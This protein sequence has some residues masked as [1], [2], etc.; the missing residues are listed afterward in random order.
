MRRVF[1]SNITYGCNSNCVFCYSHNTIH[2]GI[3]YKE[4]SAEQLFIYWKLNN[5]SKKDR[6]I[7]NGGE[8]LLHSEIQKILNFLLCVGCEVLI[9]TNGRLLNKLNLSKFNENFRFIIP[10]HGDSFLH[11]YITKVL[12]SYDETIAG[13]NCLKNSQC[14]VDIKVILNHKLISSNIHFNNMVESLKEI[15]FNN[16][17][18][19]TKMAETIISKKN[20]CKSLNMMDVA[21]R[22]KQLVDLFKNKYVVKIF[23]TCVKDILVGI[24]T[25]KIK[26]FNENIVVLF[27]D[28]N[29]EKKLILTEP[30]FDCKNNCVVSDLCMSAV[31]EYTVLEFNG[32]DIQI[33]ME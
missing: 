2:N 16:A 33:S 11:D 14:K 20:N 25:T 24:D 4:I 22:T 18:H 3:S 29:I 10:I 27:K 26:K 6:V 28:I 8:P 7:I 30:K 21:I 1:Y 15:P 23:D 13:L 31:C 17:I 12:G 9:Y 32:S 5:I 19:I